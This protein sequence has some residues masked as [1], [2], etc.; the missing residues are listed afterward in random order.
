[1]A[2][3]GRVFPAGLF[4]ANGFPA[5]VEP[6]LPDAAPALRRTAAARFTRGRFARGRF[7]S[8]RVI[9]IALA[10]G[11]VLCFSL[12]PVLVKLAYGYV[13]DPVTLLALRMLFALPFF[14]VAVAWLGGGRRR[15]PVSPRDA[16][17]VVALGCIGYYAA[18]FLDYLGLQYISAGVGRLL[19]FLYPTLV[20]LLSMLILRK[21]VTFRELLALTISYGGLALVLS[22][23]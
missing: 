12:R 14:L 16:L 7:D 8:G 11:A 18:S 4:P 5:N 10:T 22:Q 19:L 9:G 13:T 20:L 6:K 17:A 1:M 23:S 15:A 2:A 21:P 3:S